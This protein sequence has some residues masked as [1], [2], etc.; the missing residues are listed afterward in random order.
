MEEKNYTVYMH[1]NKINGK[2]YIGITKQK[3]EKRWNNGKGYKHNNYIKNAINK[4]GWE[5]IEHKILYKNLTKKEAEEKEIKLIA[6]YKSNK[7]EYGYN[8]ENGG[9]INCV[10]EETKKKLSIANKGKFVSKETREKMSKNNAKIWLGKKLNNETRQ[11]MS[12]SHKGKQSNN[13]G[14]I[15]N[16]RKKVICIET[17][18]I[19]DSITIASNI[20]KIN[21]V[22]ISEVCK[23]IRKSAGKINNIKLHWEY[24][25]E[26]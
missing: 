1:K 11:K 24:I 19:Y 22:H 26:E 14:K 9:H 16:T 6:Y 20:T 18:T 23:G 17:N 15:L 8:I 2:V 5:N 21:R 7:K 3:P 25:K 12:E 10:S 13:K 4:Y